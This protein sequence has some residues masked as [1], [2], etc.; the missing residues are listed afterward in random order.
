MIQIQISTHRHSSQS[1]FNKLHCIGSIS[2]ASNTGDFIFI[3]KGE[4]Y[5]LARQW[6]AVEPHLNASLIVKLKDSF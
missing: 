3:I 4:Q 1:I 2:T 5:Q 6:E